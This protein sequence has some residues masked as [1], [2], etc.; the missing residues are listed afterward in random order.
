MIRFV[1]RNGRKYTR[2]M[3][4]ARQSEIWSQ[5]VFDLR[6]HLGVSQDEL[7]SRLGVTRVSIVS[8]ESGK[9]VPQRLHRGLIERLEKE[10]GVHA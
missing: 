4:K 3:L 10:S 8:W 5:R 9:H 2:T 6:L 7:A 1:K